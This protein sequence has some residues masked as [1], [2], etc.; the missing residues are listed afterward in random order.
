MDTCQ[1]SM[2]ACFVSDYVDVCVRAKSPRVLNKA[3]GK[4][5]RR[6][7]IMREREEIRSGSL[8]LIGVLVV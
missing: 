1:L 8:R 3:K 2:A 6:E 4:Q 7:T 5:K